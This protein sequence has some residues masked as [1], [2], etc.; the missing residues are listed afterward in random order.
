MLD[1][2]TAIVA[3]S[4]AQGLA[5]FYLK[6]PSTA[7]APLTPIMRSM[8]VGSYARPAELH[9]AGLARLRLAA[10]ALAI[11]CWMADHNGALPPTLDALAP[12]YL[13]R[14]PLDPL[15]SSSATTNKIIYRTTT[16]PPTVSSAA[17]GVL[18]G[19]A[20]NEMT[21]RLTE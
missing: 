2:T 9:Y 5:E 14:A 6:A 11:R 3:A 10:T 15:A 12:K 7:P 16:T 13:P 20:G 8:L 21:I 17:T 1:H 4:H 18:T 19:R